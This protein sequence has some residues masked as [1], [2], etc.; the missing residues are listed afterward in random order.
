MLLRTGIFGGSFNPIHSGHIAIG[1]YFHRSGILD[2]VW[3]VVSP[4]NPLKTSEVSLNA[5]E[6][7][8]ACREVLKDYPYLTVSDIEF[9]L[10]RPSYMAQTLKSLQERYPDRQ[11]SL[12]IGGDNLAH[13]ERWKDYRQIL[14][15][16]DILVYPRPGSPNIVPENWKRVRLFEDATLMDISSTQIRE[17]QKLAREQQA[18]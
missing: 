16:Y 10:P 15:N 8:Q 17:Q 3:F 6:R 7:L 18:K 2:E 11:F 12:I 4:Q 5:E 1:E 9:E 14:D 13:F